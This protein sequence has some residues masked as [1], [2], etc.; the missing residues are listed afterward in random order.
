MQ[1]TL[2][3]D[4]LTWLVFAA[5]FLGLLVAGLS[6]RDDPAIRGDRVLRHDGPARVSHWTHALGTALLLVS[7]IVLGTRFTPSFVTGNDATA[8]WF[9]VHFVFTLLFLFGTFYWL[10]NT[11]ISRWRFREH[12]P[13]KNA[14]TYTLNHYGSL[15]GVK[16]CTYPKEAKYF[17]SERMAFILAIVATVSVLVSGLIKTLAHAL[18]LPEGF[19]NA[20]TWTHDIAAALMLLFFL[21]HVFF[22]AVLPVSWTTLR[23]MFTG[24]VPLERAKHEHAAWIEELEEQGAAKAADATHENADGTRAPHA[25]AER[26][27]GIDH[28]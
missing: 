20:M 3:F 16:K 25:S 4:Q 19:M 11:I 17:E 2:L 6:K 26:K 23:S 28:V 1:E 12:L 13:T 15:L 22:G 10:G 21:A 5:P 18:P 7:G 24:Y 27:E 9:N 14:I 8:T